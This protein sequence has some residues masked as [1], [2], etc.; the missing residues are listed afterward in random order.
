M[1]KKLL[2][3]QTKSVSMASL[4]LA[5]FY[6]A[7]AGLGLLRDHFLAGQIGT[8]KLDVYY[9]AFTIPDLIALLMVFGAI[10]SAIIP[11]FTDYFAKSED[12]AWEYASVLF[13]VFMV[14][15]I[16]VCGIFIIFA[17]FFTKLI[18]PGFS[19]E[20]QA[21]TAMLMRIMFLSPII[22]GI[23]N[24]ISGI[25][26]VFNRFLVT[27]LAPLMY[28]LGIIIGIIFLAP[29]FGLK[30]LAM[31]VVL[32][33][34][35]HL[36]IQLPAFFYSGFKFQ[37]LSFKFQSFFHPGVKKTLALMIPRSLGLGAGQINMIATTTI[38]STLVAGSIGI[39]T[40]ANNLSNML[41]SM[42]AV[43][44][45]T[46]I[47]PSLS[48]VY[49][50]ENKSEFTRKFSSAFLQLLF[51]TIPASVLLF[52]LRAQIVRVVLGS[53]YFNWTDTRLASACLGV[54]AV[55]ICFQGLIFLLSKTF[56]AAHNTKIPAI[57][58]AGTVAFNILLSLFFVWLLNAHGTFYL[59]TQSW[60]KLQGIENISVVG[61]ALS[62]SITGIAEAVFLLWLAYKYYKVFDVAVILKS[63]YK[64]I[65]S[66]V[67]MAVFILAV[68]Q[69]LV[70]LNIIK[71]QTF[72][73]VFLQLTLSAI[74]GS[75]AYLLVS[76]ILNR[77]LINGHF[78]V[79]SHLFRKS[80]L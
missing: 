9:A 40:L 63:I 32:G 66:A 51:L 15:L 8:E 57:V 21:T 48:K 27:A 3:A 76:Y 50:Q 54:F 28:N 36:A 45:S 14:C 2:N 17:P 30:G 71:L 37:A 16:A 41:V 67:V 55:G 33:G 13:N 26:Q 23:S 62:F 61:L 74:A 46:A 34:L 43:S 7:S 47:F 56:Y 73:G 70:L 10:S 68:R 4:I 1:L 69:Q 77:E 5:F 38:A 60:L 24:I 52:F 80:G 72:W 42:L 31:G 12:Q 35:L 6:V 58:S 59:A 19:P 44:I 75:V 11:I 78:K 79:F 25:L 22:L 65:I 18:T 29:Y 49:L 20:K 39:F 64:I 53:G